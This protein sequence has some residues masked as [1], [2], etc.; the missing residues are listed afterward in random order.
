MMCNFV[1]TILSC[2]QPISGEGGGSVDEAYFFCDYFFFMLPIR[3]GARRE[4]QVAVSGEAGAEE[5]KEK[6]KAITQGSTQFP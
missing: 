3:Y 2:F 4:I 6:A 5:A 1:A